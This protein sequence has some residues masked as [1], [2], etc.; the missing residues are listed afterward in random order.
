MWRQSTRIGIICGLSLTASTAVAANIWDGGGADSNWSTPNNW[1]PNVAPTSSATADIQMA[2]LIGLTPNVDS[3]NPWALDSLTFNAGAGAFTVGGNQISIEGSTNSGIFNSSSSTQIVNNDIQ[4]NNT[5]SAALFG[6]IGTSS[7]GRGYLQPNTSSPLIING[8]IT[9]SANATAAALSLYGSGV[10]EVAGQINLPNGTLQKNIGGTWKLS[11]NN[12]IIKNVWIEN[13][14]LQ[15]SS[16]ANAGSASSLGTG[17]EI[18]F[19]QT[20][21]A[22]TSVLE[23]LGSSVSTDRTMR[24]YSGGAADRVGEIRNSGAGTLTL[25]GDLTYATGGASGGWRLSGSGDGVLNGNITSIGAVLTKAGTGTWTINSTGNTDTFATVIDSGTLR[26]NGAINS[27][28]STQGG[29]TVNLN[30][31]LGGTGKIATG[32]AGAGKVDPGV[33]QGILRAV[34]VDGAGGLDFNMEFTAAASP[35]YTDTSAS[36]NDLLH[37]TGATPFVTSL[38]SGNTINIFFSTPVHEGDVYKGAFYT[39]ASGDFLS[40]IQNASFNYY[41]E[42]AGGPA[43]YGAGEYALL[44]DLFPSAAV[45][46]ETI[47]ESASFD[48]TTPING[49][50]AQFTLTGVPE[51]GMLWI[52]LGI[53]LFAATARRRAVVSKQ[54]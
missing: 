48:G 34:S 51:P 32:I 15:V 9:A 42:Q 14:V 28:S 27:S 13:G 20:G 26:I 45:H 54:V 47:L 21:S 43:I 2:G 39:D 18:Y 53:G 19:S 31:T 22:N 4:I 46:V 6:Q 36:G 8:T 30:G 12:N 16:L 40:S 5:R 44:T 17:A 52:G 38:G 41:V 24:L 25:N 1:N 37:L 3:N 10:G 50:V 33:T 35:D 7:V 11:N 49:R 23:Y 29:V